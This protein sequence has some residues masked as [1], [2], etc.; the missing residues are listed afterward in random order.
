MYDVCLAAGSC[1]FVW[2]LMILCDA[3]F[4]E[5]A[6]LCVLYIKERDDSKEP[7]YVGVTYSTLTIIHSRV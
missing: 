4:L 7:L 6:H 1:I 5:Y 3:F 2:G